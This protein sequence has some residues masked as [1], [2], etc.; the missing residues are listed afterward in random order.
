MI[1]SV[2]LK[3]KPRLFKSL[4]GITVDTFDKLHSEVAP[5]WAAAERNRLSRLDRHR[6]IGGGRAYASDL[7]E[8][9]LMTLMWLHLSLNTEALGS[10]DLTTEPDQSTN[11]TEKTEIPVGQ[12]LK[13]RKDPA[14]IL[15]FVDETFNEMPFFVKMHIILAQFLAFGSRRNNRFGFVLFN[16]KPDKI[17]GIIRFI[18]NQPLKI[19][20][21]NQGFTLSDVVPLTTGQNKAQRITQTIDTDVNFGTEAAFA[22]A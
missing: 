4:T 22:P 19:K 11:E 14:E 20:V 5:I 12:F 21:D 15:D 2:I 7:R 9:L 10:V 3:K 17:I 1:T 18:G 8:Q 6:A 16:D 13:S